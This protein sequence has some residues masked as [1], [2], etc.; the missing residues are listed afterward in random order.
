MGAFELGSGVQDT[1]LPPIVSAGSNQTVNFPTNTVVLRGSATDPNHDLLTLTWSQV[2]G[3]ASALFSAINSSNTTVTAAVPGS[4]VFRLTASDSKAAAYAD[5]SVTFNPAPGALIFE[6]ES[7]LL[8]TPFVVQ[9]S[10]VVQNTLTAATNGGRAAYVFTV[11][12]AG[13]YIITGTVNAPDGGANS[14]YVNIDA[15]PADPTM[16]WDIPVTSG[17]ESRIVS[18][19]GNGTLESPKVF[20]LTTGSHTMI[21]RG[22]EA[23]LELDKFEISKAAETPPLL[24]I[25]SIPRKVILSWPASATNYTLETR[26]TMSPQGSWVAVTNNIVITGNGVVV[27][28]N[29][30]RS[31][32]FYRL[33]KN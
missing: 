25:L 16:I 4:Y 30:D 33:R 21:V 9:N 10:Y 1:N 14:C 12:N 2:S 32:A 24:Q 17:F 20:Y 22:R 13:N 26:A 7:G 5:T 8:S 15:E 23:G 3:P 19:R 31:A 18:W 28:N 11:T 27:T 6:A 29:I